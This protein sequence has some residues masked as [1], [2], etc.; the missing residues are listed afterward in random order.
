MGNPLW[1]TTTRPTS[2]PRSSG[3]W[4]R[5]LATTF[6]IHR[7]LLRGSTRWISGSIS[8]LSAR[9]EGVHSKVSRNSYP[10]SISLSNIT[11][12]LHV[13]LHGQLRQTQS[14]KRSKDFVNLFLGQNNL[15]YISILLLQAL[16]L[17]LTP[18][19]TI[20]SRYSFPSPWGQRHQETFPIALS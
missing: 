1:W 16:I 18:G 15:G 7:H 11:T 6:T 2:T 12:P 14:W 19:Q 5:V 13:P 17:F 8:S 4:R 9:F 20:T 10:R 3:G